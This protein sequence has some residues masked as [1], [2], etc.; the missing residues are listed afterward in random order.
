[1]FP[2]SSTSSPEVLRSLRQRGSAFLGWL[3]VVAFGGMALLSIVSGETSPVFLGALV[4]AATGS[5]VLLAR[6]RVTITIEGVDLENPIRRTH[7]PWARID[8]VS[9]RWNLEVWSGE[10]VYRAW[11]IASHIDRPKR[12]SMSSFGGPDAE[13]LKNAPRPTEKATVVASARLIEDAKEEWNEMVASGHPEARLGGQVTQR[14]DW[15]DIVALSI[16]TLVIL[17]GILL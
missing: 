9:P 10:K 5:W 2:W 11:A 4:L 1:M 16:P 6:P 14:W 3:A 13:E 7:L 17:L 12:G 8:D 15:A